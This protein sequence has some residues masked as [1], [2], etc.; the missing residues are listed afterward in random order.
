MSIDD[1][2]FLIFM[3]SYEKLSNDLKITFT[4][5]IKQKNSD[6]KPRYYQRQIW[7]LVKNS[8]LIRVQKKSSVSF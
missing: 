5:H 8:K 2:L 3:E 4:R 1:V 6:K 7:N